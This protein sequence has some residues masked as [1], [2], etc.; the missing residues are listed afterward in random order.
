MNCY[1]FVPYHGISLHAL[2]VKRGFI[3]DDTPT[4]CLTGEPVLNMPQFPKERVKGIM[5]TFSL[6][7]KFDKSRW[8]E[9]KMAES[10]TPGGNRIFAALRNEYVKKYFFK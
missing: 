9:I 5:R 1:A 2:S 10:N 8:P 6:Y 3:N 7:V 4:S